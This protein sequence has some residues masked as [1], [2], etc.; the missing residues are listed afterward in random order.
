MISFCVV[1]NI[2]FTPK[3]KTRARSCSPTCTSKLISKMKTKYTEDDIQA[4]IAAKKS[5]FTITEIEE[6]TGVNRNKIKEICRN[7]N[8]LLSPNERQNHAFKAKLD[9]NPNAMTDMRKFLTPEVRRRQS[10]SINRTIEDNKDKYHKIFSDNSIKIW[11]ELKSDPIKYLEYI[12]KR[13]AAF[14][15]ARLGMTMEEY[16]NKINNI[17]MMVKLKKGSV[18][19]LA[20]LEGLDPNTICREFH[21]RGWGYLVD[22][23]ISLPEK[24]VLAWIKEIW[25]D[26]EDIIENSQTLFD[27]TRREIDIFI[28]SKK[29]CIEFNG[30]FWHSSKAPGWY[31]GKEVEKYN[32]CVSSG[33]TM[34]M[35]YEDEWR[36]PKKRDIVKSMIS[37]RL[38]V[39]SSIKLRASSLNLIRLN[40]NIEYKD[41]FEFNHLD[42]HTNSSYAYALV[43]NENKIISAMSFRRSYSGQLEIARFATDIR[44]IVHGNASKLLSQIKET[45]ITYSDNRFSSGDVYKK[46]GFIEITKS[47]GPNYYYT[48]F[49]QRIKRQY[50]VKRD[51]TKE[52]LDLGLTTEAKQAAAGLFSEKIFGSRIPLYRIEGAGTKKWIKEFK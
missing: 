9:K 29:F 3:N 5:G 45:L 16:E 39:T 49:T 14:R 20:R 50:C 46:M 1:C 17:K 37:H 42:G 2:E 22:G 25:I 13:T 43:D 24:E 31:Y 44:Y 15:E 8:T 33:Y 28:K 48:D 21:K 26:H 32:L 4:V 40:K 19:G 52:G 12:E 38:G 47:L 7:H 11:Q 23:G 35:I 34:F 27:N 36:D 51:L 41:F 18:C 30:L 6:I 10:I